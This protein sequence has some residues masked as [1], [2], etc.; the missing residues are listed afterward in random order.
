MC[1]GC[2]LMHGL[3]AAVSPR[4]MVVRMKHGN[5]MCIIYLCALKV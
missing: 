2:P 1:L 3:R 4:E 5:A